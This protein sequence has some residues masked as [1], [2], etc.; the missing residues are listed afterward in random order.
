MDNSRKEV[1]KENYQRIKDLIGGRCEF[2]AVTKKVGLEEVSYLTELGHRDFGQN[3]V[4][5][6]EEKAHKLADLNIDWH[7]IGHLQ[8]NKAKKLLS[9]PKLKYIHSIDSLK[10]LKQFEKYE[11]DLNHDILCFLQVNTSGEEEK[12]GFINESQILEAIDYFKNFK[13][14]KLIGL[15]TI[16][17]IRTENFEADAKKS[18]EQLNQMMMSHKFQLLTSGDFFQCEWIPRG[19]KYQN[20][21]GQIRY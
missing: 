1:I 10:L 5:D 21:L 3:K 18:F 19:G 7:F 4:Q 8:S 2:V 20:Q 9:I 6:L 13:N 11:K 14:L 17:K 16:G 15:M 12:S